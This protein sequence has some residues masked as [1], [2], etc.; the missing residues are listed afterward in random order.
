M[1]RLYEVER[2][3]TIWALVDSGRLM[4]A[5]TAGQSKLDHAVGAVL[6]MAQ[7]ALGGGDRVGLI[8]YGRTHH[9]AAA[10]RARA[11]APQAPPRRAGADDRRRVGGRSRAGRGPP[12]QRSAAPGARRVDHRP[13]R[14]DDDSGSRAGGHASD[15]RG[16]SC[17]SWSSASR[18]S[19]RRRRRTPAERGRDVRDGRRAGGDAAAR[20]AAC[21]S[22]GRAARWRSRRTPPAWRLRSCDG[23]LEVKQRNRV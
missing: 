18:T 9:A 2:S 23:Y 8:A 1:T 3:Q 14:V 13:G 15:A 17:C 6:A 12:A 4:R 16:M 19:R 10:C 21:R 5:R 7:V 20:G 22:C 11:G